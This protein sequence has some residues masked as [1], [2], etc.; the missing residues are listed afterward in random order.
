MPETSF[1]VFGVGPFAKIT[2]PKE[3]TRLNLR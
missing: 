2:D 3:V 1:S